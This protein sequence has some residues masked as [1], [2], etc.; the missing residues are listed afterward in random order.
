METAT[1]RY[2][3]ASPIVLPACILYGLE[4]KK[5]MPTAKGPL[6]ALQMT[7]IFA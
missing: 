3:L 5:M 7:L 6:T 4:K 2:L 1:S